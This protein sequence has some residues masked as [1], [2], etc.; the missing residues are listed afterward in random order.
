M[1]M[2]GLMLLVASCATKPGV[3]AQEPKESTPARPAA[4][5]STAETNAAPAERKGDEE[6][7]K[8]LVDAF[9]KA[10]N[11]GDAKAVAATYTET[12]LVVDE[13]GGRVEGLA[14]IRDQYA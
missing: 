12:A 14:A 8:A 2:V 4:T 3:N 13:Q 9:T 7:I 11:A 1:K 6:A 5:R 10:F